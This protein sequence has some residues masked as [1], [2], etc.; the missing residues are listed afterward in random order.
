MVDLGYCDVEICLE[1]PLKYELGLGDEVTVDGFPG[2]LVV[3]AVVGPQRIRITSGHLRYEPRHV[4]MRELEGP[5]NRCKAVHAV[6][7]LDNG[8][9][10]TQ[11]M[12]GRGA[13]P[14]ELTRFP[15]P[16]WRLADLGQDFTGCPR[17]S[18]CLQLAGPSRGP[19]PLQG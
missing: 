8:A 3:S 17:C 13:V 16:D 2:P 15:R 14:G 10:A 12:C 5:E 6:A 11:S 9:P 1:N 4:A 18:T 19:T 7:I